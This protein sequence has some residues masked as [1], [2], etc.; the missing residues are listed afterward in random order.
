MEEEHMRKC[1]EKVKSLAVQGQTLALAAA[2][3][4][5]F[6]WK[7]TPESWDSKVPC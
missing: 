2:E 7:S 1:S 5:D 3:K 4:N 6:T